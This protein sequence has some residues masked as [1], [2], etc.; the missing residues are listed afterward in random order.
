[1][2]KEYVT[3]IVIG[4]TAMIIGFFGGRHFERRQTRKY[5]RSFPQGEMIRGNPDGFRNSN[6]PDQNGVKPSTSAPV[7]Q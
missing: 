2:K 1:M 7:A 3:Y 6:V 4:V 5:F